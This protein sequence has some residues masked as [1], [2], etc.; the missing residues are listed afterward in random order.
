MTI[1]ELRASESGIGMRKYMK[2]ISLKTEYH[3]GIVADPVFT[4]SDLSWVSV[5]NNIQGGR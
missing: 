2:T 3:F 1:T 5:K 4:Q